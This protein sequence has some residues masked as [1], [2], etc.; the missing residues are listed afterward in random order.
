[1]KRLIIVAALLLG[2][3]AIAGVARPEGSHAA[4]PTTTPQRTITVTGTGTASSTPAQAS[5]SFG[6][7]AQGATAKAALAENA[8]EMRKVIAALESAGAKDVTTE[9]VSLS[10]VVGDNQTV[11]GYM[12]VN[13]VSAT[14]TYADAGATIDA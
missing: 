6:V 8:T 11:Q 5:V 14:V 2:A 7:P 9:S 12:A 13:T 10:P 3:A 1:M 4:D